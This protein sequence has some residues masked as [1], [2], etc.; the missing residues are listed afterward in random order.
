[1]GVSRVDL[2]SKPRSLEVTYPL[3]S[4][5]GIEILFENLNHLKEQRYMRG[6][7]AISDLVIDLDRALSEADLTP[8]EEE[9]LDF[10]YGDD[11]TYLDAS[12]ASKY[13]DAGIFK[14]KNR[15]VVKLADVF[16]SWGYD[17]VY[18]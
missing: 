16:T 6:N 4:V 17:H 13:S 15:A 12:K 3:T 7:F 1:M 14:A 8:I 18:I 9:A 5:D 2:E 10:I 11:L